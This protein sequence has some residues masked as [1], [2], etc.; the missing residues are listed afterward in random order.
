MITFR[1]TIRVKKQ[2]RKSK[3]LHSVWQITRKN[4]K[5][6]GFREILQEPL[7]SNYIQ[8]LIWPYIF[9]KKIPLCCPTL[10]YIFEGGS[11]LT[12]CTVLSTYVRSHHNL[13]KNGYLHLQARILFV[14]SCFPIVPR[15]CY[16]LARNVLCTKDNLVANYFGSV[17]KDLAQIAPSSMRKKGKVA[18]RG[19]QNGANASMESHFKGG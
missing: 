17:G 12:F 1:G 7:I 16:F 13:R 4:P 2:S 11:L 10:H 5:N 15:E 3:I 6:K 19:P 9:I 14:L 18:G 8:L